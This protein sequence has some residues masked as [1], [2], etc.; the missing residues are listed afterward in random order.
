MHVGCTRVCVVQ[1]QIRERSA[2]VNADYTHLKIVQGLSSGPWKNSSSERATL[3]HGFDRPRP[4]ER[5]N[6]IERT[7]VDNHNIGP[8]AGFE[9][10]GIIEANY[11]R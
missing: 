6:V 1:S 8:P 10:S 2:Y 4:R 5:S 3:Q 11:R 7:A 9:R